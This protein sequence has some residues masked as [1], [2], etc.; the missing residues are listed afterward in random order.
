MR[1]EF[2]KLAEV[3]KEYAGDEVVY[4]LKNQGNWGD[5]LILQGTFEFF[6][7]FNVRYRTLT[8]EQTL[9]EKIKWRLA[10]KSRVLVVSGG[11]AWCGHYRE[12]Q[13]FVTVVARKYK[14]KKI[15]VL[16]STFEDGVSCPNTIFFRRDNMES[17]EVMPDSDF[18]HDMAFFL[19][20]YELRKSSDCRR[21]KSIGYCF[22]G[23]PEA[24][25]K[26]EVPDG[27]FDLSAHGNEST[28]IS[29]FLEWVANKDVIHTDRLH[30]T[31]AGGLLG[32]QVYVYPG[33]YFK[34][35]A[36]YESSIKGYFDG[37]VYLEQF[38]GQGIG[39][40]RLPPIKENLKT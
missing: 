2:W 14:F 17:K 13:D 1:P 22:R 30:V 19:P 8:M 37:V 20:R 3:I 18:C 39:E 5:A 27:N 32:K 12:L 24:S 28:P 31:I 38:Q 21:D 35:R 4:F 29:G 34:N 11:G 10:R 7:H 40:D 23:D 25:G 33:C 9:A 16:P 15:I 6:R 36:L 26:H